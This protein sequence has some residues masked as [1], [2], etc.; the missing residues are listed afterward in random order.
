MWNEGHTAFAT[1]KE[2]EKEMKDIMALWENICKNYLA[3][4]FL[5]GQKSDKEKF[6]GAE[7]TW[8]LEFILPNGKAIQGPDAHFDGQNFAKAF[9]IKFLD[10]K[11]KSEYVYQNTWAF[12][13]RMIGIMIAIHG[14]DKGL[15]LPPKIATNK[16]VIVPILFKKEKEKVLKKAKEIKTKLNKYNVIL[17]EREDYSVGWKFNEWELKGIPIRVEIGP[18]DVSQK[19]VVLVRRDTN[20]KKIVKITNL[21]KEVSKLLEDIQNNLYL[22]SKKFLKSSIVNVKNISEL[23][24]QVEKGKIGKA[25]WCG[26]AGC[27]ENI[28]AKTGAKSL[29]FELNK[30]GTGKCFACVAKAKYVTYFGKS[31]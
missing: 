12:S 22:K 6:A 16:V 4:D 13:T 29:N 25:N 19:Q 31:Y 11:E 18:K 5:S 30:K 8:S 14:D 9:D 26:I 28:K 7:Y 15:I 3:L 10:K 27:E 20:E 2:A 23:K 17:D 21:D 24:K 1:K